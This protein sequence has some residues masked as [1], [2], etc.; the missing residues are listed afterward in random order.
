MERT[1]VTISLQC[2]WDKRKHGCVATVFVTVL[3]AMRSSR[4][5]SLSTCEAVSERASANARTSAVVAATHSSRLRSS[6]CGGH[7]QFQIEVFDASRSVFDIQ[8]NVFG[9]LKRR[10]F[11]CWAFVSSNGELDETG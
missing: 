5:S 11:S 4:N 10:M 8:N 1:P 9:T 6:L 2:L 7:A 3:G